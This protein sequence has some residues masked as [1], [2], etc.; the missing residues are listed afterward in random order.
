MKKIKIKSHSWSWKDKFKIKFKEI[1]SCFTN[2]F[3]SWTKN[4]TK[5][6]L[7]KTHL[8]IK[9]YQLWDRFRSLKI[10]IISQKRYFRPIIK[11]FLEILIKYELIAKELM[12]LQPLLILKIDYNHWS[13]NK[14]TNNNLVHT[15]LIHKI[16][17]NCPNEIPIMQKKTL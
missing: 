1:I 17:L 9:K 16:Q 3:K 7:R 15:M 13:R 5:L 6:I 8:N 14:P 12:P 10:D 2:K 4:C 11:V